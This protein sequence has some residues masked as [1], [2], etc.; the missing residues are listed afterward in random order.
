MGKIEQIVHVLMGSR[1][2]FSFSLRER[3][4]LIRHILSKLQSLS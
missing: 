2:Y 1:F 3:Y 4:D